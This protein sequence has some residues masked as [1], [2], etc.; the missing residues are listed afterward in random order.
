TSSQPTARAMLTPAAA[1]P[2]K[3]LLTRGPRKNDTRLV[4][5]CDRPWIAA[6][7]DH[8]TASGFGHLNITTAIEAA[9][10][11]K[12]PW[13][14][15]HKSHSGETRSASGAHQGG[16]AEQ[17]FDQVHH[18][19]GGAVVLVQRRVQF[20]DVQRGR[21]PCVRD[22]FH[23]QLGFAVGRSAWHGGADR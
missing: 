18:Q 23:A 10:Y 20:H 16:L 15:S 6:I 1:P 9:R 4:L 14:D 22:H 12:A 2:L 3:H 7:P 13:P 8:A 17:A 11:G 21:Q 5:S 19:L